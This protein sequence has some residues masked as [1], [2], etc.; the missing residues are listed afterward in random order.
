MVDAGPDQTVNEGDL[1]LFNGYFA[2]PGWL[3]THTIVWDFGDGSPKVTGLLY[4]THTYGDNGV[5]TVTLTVTDSDGGIGSDTLTI[6]V[7]NAAPTVD[8][9]LDKTVDE[10]SVVDFAGVFTDPGC[11]DTYTFSWNFGDGSDPVTG[12]ATTPSTLLTSHVYSYPGVYTITLTVTD[13]DGGVGTESLVVTVLDITPPT[14]ILN[15]LGSYHVDDHIYI[16]STATQI[17]LSAEDAEMPHG[18]GVNIIQYQIDSTDSAGWIT[19]TVPFTVDVIDTHTIYY[20]SID[21]V[22]N[23]EVEQSVEVVV[24][25]SELIY[26]DEPIEVLRS[27]HVDVY[28]DPAYLQARLI[29]IAT[30]LPIPGKTIHFAVGSQTGCTTTDSDGYAILEIVLDQQAETYPVV[31]WFD[32]D[33]EYLASQSEIIDF[34]I[35][36]ETAHVE[37][38]GSTVVPTTVSTIN[39]RATVLDDDDGTWG[40][41]TKIYVTFRIYTMPLGGLALYQ[42]HGPYQ[43]EATVIAGVGVFEIPITNL[44][45]D[46]YII[47]ICLEPDDNAYYQS[48][49]SEDVIITVYEPTGDFVTGGGWIYD[50]DG[51]RGNFGFNVKYKK[52]GLPKGQFVYI[53]RTGE[54]K[55]RIKSTAWLGMAIIED[56]SFFEAKCVVEQYDAETDELIWSEG[57]YIVRVDVWDNT[58][59]EGLEDV[60]QLRVYGKQGLVYYESGFDPYGTLQGGS[61]VIHTDEEK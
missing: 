29:D 24:N 47:R 42:T 1:V 16:S 46:C 11:L 61:I 53:Y 58:G 50:S 13:N 40:D 6:T 52:N 37:Y 41:L 4:S 45:E 22:G 17:E 18:S 38:T 12:A 7:N 39:I 48:A 15:F 20:R 60:F 2:D 9:G 19:Y 34:A 27:T 57:N 32:K 23:V 54:Y 31:A 5:Y 49:P 36:K 33:E 44:P 30:Q 8:A 51:T 21:N 10:D 43:I 14:T 28:S 3:D 59:T 25:A 26:L 55:F 35:E 56:H